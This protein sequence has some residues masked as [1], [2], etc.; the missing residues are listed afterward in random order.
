MAKQCAVCNQSYPE[1]LP[2]CPYC[3]AAN[4]AF[5][6]E[7]APEQSLPFLLPGDSRIDL[8][9]QPPPKSGDSAASDQAL[10]ALLA[11]TPDDVIEVLPEGSSAS[12]KKP[13]G[14]D[15]HAVVE[16]VLEVVPENA[17]SAKTPV[18]RAVPPAD[19]VLEVLPEDGA[20]PLPAAEADSAFDGPPLVLPESP[21][22]GSGKVTDVK[23]SPEAA[24]VVSSASG[25]LSPTNETADIPSDI[26]T[27]LSDEPPLDLPEPVSGVSGEVIVA[28][29]AAPTGEMP[30]AE[31]PEPAASDL[32]ATE[33]VAPTF[34]SNMP[35]LELDS[36]IH[37]DAKADDQVLDMTEVLEVSEASSSSMTAPPPR[38]SADSD[39]T[40]A[41][42]AAGVLGEE[43]LDVTEEA[44]SGALHELAATVVP[45]SAKAKD[46]DVTL[47]PE[48]D[49]SDS[50][51]L[52]AE[53]VAEAADPSSKTV[54]SPVKPEAVAQADELNE[55]LAFEP[56]AAAAADEDVLGHDVVVEGESSGKVER[57]SGVDLIAEALESGVDLAGTGKKS[58]SGRRLSEVDLGGPEPEDV[59]DSAVNL[60]SPT[61]PPRKDKKEDSVP[62]LSDKS[63]ED[64]LMGPDEPTAQP[65]SGTRSDKAKTLGEETLGEDALFTAPPDAETEA[66]GEAEAVAADEEEEV[67][68]AKGKKGVTDKAAKPRRARYVLV[69]ILLGLLVL[70]GAA[71]GAWFVDPARE[72]AME[73]LGLQKKAPPPTPLQLAH[74]F[75][76]K[77]DYNNAVSKLEG[78]GQAPDVASA[79]AQARWLKYLQDNKDVDENAPEVK[80]ALDESK[81]AHN[82]ALQNQI[83][84]AVDAQKAKAKLGEDEKALEAVQKTLVDAKLV[85]G[86]EVDVKILPGTIAKLLK[87]KKEAEQVVSV[88]TRELKVPNVDPKEMPKLL[89]DLANAKTVMSKLQMGLKVDD[90]DALEK[91]VLDIQSTRNTL[92]AELTD[93]NKK[94]KDAKVEDKGGAGVAKLVEARNT[95]EKERMDLDAVVKSA[96]DALKEENLTP[97]G[98]EPRKGLLEATKLA[99]DK[100]RT[101]LVIS[102]GQMAAAVGGLGAEVNGIVQR[103][104]DA[105][106]LNA[107][108]AYYRGREPLIQ[109]PEQ[110]LDTWAALLQDRSHNSGPELTAATNE[111]QWVLANPRADAAAKARA[112]YVIGLADR[113]RGKFAEARKA[114]QQAVDDALAA[115]APWAP[116]AK[117]AQGEL[118]DAAVY[119]LPRAQRLYAAGDLRASLAELDSAVQVYPEDGRLLALRGLVRLEMSRRLDAEAQKL[120]RQD[121]E[122]AQKDGK[123]RAEGLYVLGRLE[124][125]LGDFEKAEKDYRDAIQAH[126]GSEDAASRYIIALARLLQRERLGAPEAPPAEPEAPKKDAKVGQRSAEPARDGLALLVMALTGFQAADED[127]DPNLATRVRE[128]IDLANRL[129]R[130]G[131]KQGDDKMQGQ[132]Y[133]LLGKA[134][135]LQGDRTKGLRFYVKGMQMA[136]PD[137]ATK[138]L[139]KMVEDHPGLQGA[140]RVGPPDSYVADRHFGKGLTLFWQGDYPAAEEQFRKAVAY[141]EPDAR[142]HYYLGLSRLLQNTKRKREEAR[143]NFEQ[144][145]RFEAENRPGPVMVNASLER[146]QGPLR[147]YLDNYRKGP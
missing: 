143:F 106:K 4:P 16:D 89:K 80:K 15:M 39:V 78:A 30:A 117:Q 138:D 121:A 67:A 92:D 103:S 141:F 94:L 64:L 43:V 60:G 125:R 47:V 71:A 55:T 14:V 111:A 124:E 126:Q 34:V 113:N 115:K 86:K 35:N 11:D 101:P 46:S 116:A 120:I 123:A 10:H 56:A 144:G 17:P 42:E 79:R 33:P 20:A 5:S 23:P 108:L 132:G 65:A 112:H 102:L 18:A 98:A 49:D 62:P 24:E 74:G 58:P 12:G 84:M 122:A 22:G 59:P 147:D 27:M 145:A 69:G 82:K 135:T 137:L 41:E 100:A 95:L 57:P 142:Y 81:T 139:L 3:K 129:I 90:P 44:S 28:A 61:A 136:Y 70:G 76:D 13:A 29:E 119:Y 54:R 48:P 63:I 127:E 25:K 6:K 7:H 31:I 75:M 93:I 72:Q 107:E 109:T 8:G 85:D 140:E 99:L 91:A 36:K 114:F 110:K 130:A 73:L 50:D 38:A 105:A 146:L 26:L 45:G 118:T 37:K 88:I 2:A 96:F 52:D 66:E 19:D 83:E 87:D 68:P 133:I 1:H 9:T 40:V 134:Y 77:G 53:E 51:V 21:S 131:K 104:Y 97:P 128:S 32:P